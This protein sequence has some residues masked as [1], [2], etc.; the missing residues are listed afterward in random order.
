MGKV[1]KIEEQGFFRRRVG[2]PPEIKVP[3]GMPIKSQEPTSP[4]QN[5]RKRD[6]IRK[7][8]SRKEN[9]VQKTQG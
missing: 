7:G 5:S 3:G 4:L 2:E 8:P 6:F 9:S 1:Q